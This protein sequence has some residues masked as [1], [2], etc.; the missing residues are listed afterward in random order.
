[1]MRPCADQTSRLIWANGNISRDAPLRS[2]ASKGRQEQGREVRVGQ[3]RERKE[4]EEGKGG[5]GKGAGRRPL[6][7]SKAAA[8]TCSA[9]SVYFSS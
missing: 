8:L 2:G 4:A 5:S 7:R 6:K 3:M 1:M 9:S